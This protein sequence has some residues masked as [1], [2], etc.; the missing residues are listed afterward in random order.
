MQALS[1]LPPLELPFTRS[2]PGYK[3]I[4]SGR[5][6]RWLTHKASTEQAM[7]DAYN[8]QDAGA[9]AESVFNHVSRLYLGKKKSPYLDRADKS[10][11]P[12]ASA[13]V[14]EVL[15]KLSWLP[16]ERPLTPYDPARAP[17]AWFINTLS[18]SRHL[19][20]VK[21]YWAT[22]SATVDKE[23][24]LTD[25]LMDTRGIQSAISDDQAEALAQFL[26]TLPENQRAL[27][28]ECLAGQAA[29]E[30]RHRFRTLLRRA[31][32][33]GSKMQPRVPVGPSIVC[34]CHRCAVR[35]WSS[36]EA[37]RMVQEQGTLQATLTLFK[38]LPSRTPRPAD[39]Y[40]EPTLT[41]SF[42]DPWKSEGRRHTKPKS[43]DKW[44]P[45]PAKLYRQLEG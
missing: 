38:G 45:I 30:T 32:K 13:V 41:G 25:H 12:L 9:L 6:E 19:S 11:A 28:D 4:S 15:R 26:E 39:W 16:H 22:K 27:A 23:R 21:K 8:A 24:E 3:G 35:P 2:N 42:I 31:A 44:E 40:F 29:P 5:L 33:W 36:V 17:F 7:Q 14:A 37:L 20:M 43:T 18:R 1:L 34:E 10:N